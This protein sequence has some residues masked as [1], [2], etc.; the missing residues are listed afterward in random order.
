MSILENGK[1]ALFKVTT[2][3][4]GIYY[5]LS[6]SMDSAVKSAMLFFMCPVS[7]IKSVEIVQFSD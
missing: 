1:L 2:T 3:K 5:S 7:S 6:N 4:G